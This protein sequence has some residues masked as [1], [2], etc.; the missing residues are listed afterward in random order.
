MS[1][2]ETSAAMQL[3][4][5]RPPVTRY[6][7]AV[8]ACLGTAT[9]ATPLRQYLDLAN[10][11]M[12]FLLTVLLVALRAGRGPAVLAAM[13]SVLLFDFLFVPPRFSL[14]VGNVQYVVTLGV[15]LAVAL[16]TAQLTAG[17]RRQAE[18]ASRRERETR[19]LYELARDLA[20]AAST[21][22]VAAITERFI[23]EAAGMR[24][25][26]LLPD[27][28]DALVAADGDAGKLAYLEERLALLAYQRGETIT[29]NALDAMG[30]AVAYVPLKAPMRV[31]GVL[32]VASPTGSPAPQGPIDAILST[33][34]S[35]VAI[36]VER[37]HYVHVA[38]QAQTE[39]ASERLRNSILSALSHDVRT[40]LTAIVGLADSLT[41]Q[42][43]PLPEGANETATAIR[44]QAA[45][46]SSMVTNLLDMARL[47]AGKVKPR[48]EWQLLEEV[49]GAAV[50]LLRPALAGHRVSIDLPEAMPLIEFDAVLLERVFCNLLE[51]AAKYSAPD[52]PIAIN[53]QLADGFV[54]VSVIDEGRG[55]PD[56]R[57]E[58]FFAL[59][60]RGEHESS[61]PGA[62]LGLAISRSIVEAHGGAIHADNR[63]GGGAQVTF[64]LP[65]GSP[66]E[67]EEE[68]ETASWEAPRG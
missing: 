57:L 22:Q 45:R 15:M 25:V 16:I 52:S 37:L 1:G 14:A 48:K 2:K 34:A 60:V 56:G 17:L 4:R 55:F 8:V 40:P 30:Q 53:A 27:A 32:A 65:L 62:G 64:T 46:L 35:L 63:P 29:V 33:F 43:P 66:P 7:W 41:V 9:V 31:R 10:I 12:L 47:A 49:A 58:E 36:A 26:L 13:L 67:I 68:A 18:V 44:E 28:H 19:S 20:G 5:E 38:N 21:M 54:H 24:A 11:V 3:A 6:A 39:M 23:R 50:Q 42:K 59:F 61:V 51:N